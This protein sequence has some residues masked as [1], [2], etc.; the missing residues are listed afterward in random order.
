M[1][2]ARQNATVLWDDCTKHQGS[3]GVCIPL[4]S[5]RATSHPGFS[6]GLSPYKDEQR[7]I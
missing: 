3:M 7:A 5:D 1:R 4:I 2:Y 6:G